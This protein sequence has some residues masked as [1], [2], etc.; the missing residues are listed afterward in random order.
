GDVLDYRKITTLGGCDGLVQSIADGDQ[1]AVH[2]LYDRS[3]RAVFTLLRRRTA[4]VRLAEE[5][6]IEVYADAW[7]I[8]RTARRVG[9]SPLA[10][11]MNLARRRVTERL[12]AVSR[13]SADDHWIDDL[14]G[15]QSP[16]PSDVAG[17]RQISSAMAA[18]IAGLLP[19]ERAAV[20]GTFF[21]GRSYVEF[22]DAVGKPRETVLGC[23]LSAVRRLKGDGRAISMCREAASVA[24]Y[25]LD[26]LPRGSVGAVQAHLQGCGACRGEL[27][28]FRD[29]VKRLSWWPTDLLRPC[30]TLRER[31]IRRIGDLCE[32]GPRPPAVRD[33]TEPAW[34]D[35]APGIAC[36]VLEIGSADDT[37]GMLVRLAPGG[38]YPAHTH[39]GL[40]ELHLLDGELWI[41]YRKLY[42][43]DYNRGEP[44]GRDKHVWSETGCMCVLVTSARDRLG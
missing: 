4:S 16:H 31:V 10:W 44:G 32:D 39:A 21:A 40:E 35:V 7:S 19:E 36:K 17:G 2:A 6:T 28:T 18:S 23:L 22:A 38:E 14:L 13:R 26:A 9:P 8:A 33:W 43:G 25:S 29:L 34:R 5:L 1:A 30:G 24:G 12:R 42:A 41:D 27:N 15:L 20:E 37:V 11:I 3:Y